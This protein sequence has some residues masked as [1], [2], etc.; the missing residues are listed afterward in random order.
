MSLKQYIGRNV[1]EIAIELGFYG[2]EEFRKFEYKLWDQKLTYCIH[3]RKI[4]NTSDILYVNVQR[5]KTCEEN[6][7]ECE[8]KELVRA[9]DDCD[10]A[11]EGLS[12][13]DRH[14]ELRCWKSDRPVKKEATPK[15]ARD[16]C[17]HLCGDVVIR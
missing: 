1:S 7:T 5:C 15:G 8:C 6:R 17:C 16:W 13:K 14:N 3:C 2:G 11:G 10:N 9:W 12:D 4:V